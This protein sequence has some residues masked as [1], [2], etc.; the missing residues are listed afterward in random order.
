[1]KREEKHQVANEI[2]E[3]LSKYK[4]FYITDISDLTVIQNNEL[5]RLCHSRGVTLRVVKNTLIRKAL[6]NAGIDSSQFT[7]VLKGFSSVMFA[8]G[9]S[10]AAKLI[11]EFR[12][13]SERPVL[14][15]AYIDESLYIGDDKLESLLKLKSKQELIGEVLG[16]LQS[17]MQKVIS[18]LQNGGNTIAGIVK[19]LSEKESN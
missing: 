9:R 7:G 13:S 2:S 19:T 4:N 17:P 8:E 10:T 12:K 5:R 16:M 11:E 1:M 14:K 15:A 6:E 18:A 3:D